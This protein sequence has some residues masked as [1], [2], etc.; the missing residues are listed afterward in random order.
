MAPAVQK[1]HRSIAK[2][3]FRSLAA[4]SNTASTSRVLNLGVIARRYADD[5]EH[6]QFPLF[7]SCL[8]QSIILKH[9]LRRDELSLFPDERRYATKVIMPFDW[10]DLALGGRS[11]FY[12]QKSF[13]ETLADELGLSRSELT[14]DE[15]ILGLIDKLPSLDPFLMR[16]HLRRHHI[17]VGACYFDIS[18][19]DFGRMQE[20][21]ARELR[22]LIERA[23]G[24]GKPNSSTQLSKMVSA[25]LSADV[26]EKLEPLRAVIGLD[27]K[28]F[29]DGAFS[30]KGFLYYKWSLSELDLTFAQ[31]LV[32]VKHLRLSGPADQR[33]RNFVAETSANLIRALQ[34]E[35]ATVREALKVYDDAFVALVQRGDARAFREF[36]LSAPHMFLEIGEKIGTI[37]H[38]CSFWRFRFPPGEP[39]FMTAD[40]ADD[41]FREYDIGVSDNN[42]S[43]KSWNV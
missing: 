26:D 38:L 11:I 43:E 42:R 14:H 39:P 8:N 25:I 30:W 40:E 21:V 32:S 23:S 20:F 24:G 34:K 16:E 1:A 3:P 36:L 29:R 13:R 18:P 15:R 6:A 12:G 19:G 4:L 2:L 5:P 10:S 22:I 28:Q 9:Q 17:K 7:K 27:P 31:T 35:R 37:S 41:F 33:A